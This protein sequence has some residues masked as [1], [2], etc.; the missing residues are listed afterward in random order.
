[1][2]TQALVSQLRTDGLRVTEWTDPAGTS[3]AEHAHPHREVRVVLEGEITFVVGSRVFV[4]GPGDRIDFA[5]GEVHAA[6]IGRAGATYLAG[7][8]R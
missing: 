7:T 6:R 3:Y 1:V 8:A 2:D 5:A 4:L